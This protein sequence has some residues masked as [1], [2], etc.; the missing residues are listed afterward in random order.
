LSEIAVDTGITL[1]YDEVGNREDPALVLVHGVSMSRRY[2]HKQLGPLAAGNRVIAV[3]LRGHGGSEK[4]EAGYTIPQCARDLDAF[5]RALDISRPV[6]LGW[7]MGTFVVFEY[8]RQFGTGS[9]R[10]VIDVDEAATDFKW[11]DFPHGFVDLPTLHELI[12]DAQ[13]DHLAF[14]QHLVPLMFHHEQS[15]DD[16]A[17]MV[18]ECARL[19]VGGLTAILFDQS[20]Q[21]YRE[22]LPM[23]D[24]PTLICWGRHDAILPVSGAPYM[25]EHIPGARLELF[26]D[27]GHCPFIEES[28]RFNEIV[29]GFLASV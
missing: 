5:M 29:D 1:A 15:A 19:P 12:S 2:F 8:I 7:S 17:W 6:L 22:L 11:D 21:D 27:S 23:I 20:L 26:E 13:T 10:G 16:V 9:I 24:V 18:A 14:L 4:V 25:L 3:D 28:E